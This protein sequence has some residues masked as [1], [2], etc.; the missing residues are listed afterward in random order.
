MTNCRPICRASCRSGRLDL[1]TEGL[2][3]LTTDGELKRQLELPRPVSSA[4]IARAPSA[5]SAR[6][7][8]RI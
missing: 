2:L 4:P 5:P 8:S 6:R 7:S 1:N 3:L